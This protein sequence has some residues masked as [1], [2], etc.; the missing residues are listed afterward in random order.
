MAIEKIDQANPPPLKS[1]IPLQALT[2]ARNLHSEPLDRL[3][4]ESVT[5]FRRAADYI[6]AGRHCYS[7][8]ER[9]Q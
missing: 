9:W 1:Q 6:A 3:T 4:A 7:L 2:L 8:Y 5:A